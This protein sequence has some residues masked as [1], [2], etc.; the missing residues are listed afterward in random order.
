[1]CGRPIFFKIMKRIL[2]VAFCFCIAFS[3]TAC[4][5][6]KEPEPEPETIYTTLYE[7]IGQSSSSSA[8]F[9]INIKNLVVT[10]VFENYAQLE[11]GTAGAQLNKKEHP[12]KAGQ[13]ING[14]I[15]GKARVT[16]GALVLTL[17]EAGDAELTETTELPC[18]K[19]TL[20]EIFADKERYTNKR[21]KLENVTFVNGFKGDANGAGIF[22]QK[23][24]QI[25]ATCRPEGVVIPDG[26]Q[27]DIVCYPSGASC[28]VFDGS[29]FTEHEINSPITTVESYGVY[30]MVGDE[31]QEFLNYKAGKNQYSFSTTDN[32][33]E[34]RIQNYKE[35]WVASFS[36]PTK[37]KLG[38]EL[39]LTTSIMGDVD[40]EDGESTVFVEKNQNGKLYLIDYANSLGYVLRVDTEE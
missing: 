29:D 18:A 33:R 35:E 5:K 8:E 20:T 7:L 2:Q 30:K 9:D 32:A 16:S 21:V 13:V 27:G 38:M 22:S 17:L 28:Y 11:D 37:M 34:F 6:H 4:K 24:M 26:S 36:V 39:K 40:L 23:G 12:F 10:A 25:P 1:M 15:T 14:H 3:L 31:P 19:I